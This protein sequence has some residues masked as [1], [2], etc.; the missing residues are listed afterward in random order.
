MDNYLELSE[1]EEERFAAKVRQDEHEEV[2]AM[3]M[4][5]SEALAEREALGK[6]E[7]VA[8][9]KLVATR[10]AI[11]SLPLSAAVCVLMV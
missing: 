10:D 11:L 8:H 2:R 9:G 4:T 7:G 1:N 3:I 5:F 6:A